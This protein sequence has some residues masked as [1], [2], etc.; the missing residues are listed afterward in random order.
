MKPL[1]EDW[2]GNSLAALGR[3]YARLLTIGL[4]GSLALLAACQE[5]EPVAPRVI[6]EEVAITPTPFEVTR[7]VT[8]E[9][10]V[11][12][13]PTPLP[14]IPPTPAPKDLTICLP[15]EPE[16]LYPYDL[17][18]ENRAILEPVLHAL[19]EDDFTRRSFGYQARGLEK[20]PSLADGDAVLEYTAVREGEWVV[21]S[22]GERVRLQ[23]GV[24]VL[25]ASG[26]EVVFSSGTVNMTQMTVD[27][28]MKPRMWSDGQPVSAEDSVL[29]FALQQAGEVAEPESWVALTASYEAIAPRTVRWTG[30]PGAQ[31][32]QYFTTFARPVPAHL[33]ENE[34]HESISRLVTTVPVGDGPFVLDV[35]RSG[36]FIR[37]RPNP[38]YYVAGQPRLDTLTFRFATDPSQ[39]L[40]LLLAGECQI[41]PPALVNLDSI[42]ALLSSQNVGELTLHFETGTVFE[43]IDFGID[44]YGVYGDNRPDWFEDARVR[45]AVALCT[46]RQQMVDEMLFGESEV[47]HSYVPAVHPLHPDAIMEW[48]YDPERGNALLDEVGFLDG[49]D[50]GI[51]EFE[52]TL[53][54]FRGDPFR[55][56]LVADASTGLVRGMIEQFQADMLA[57]GIEVVA[58]FQTTDE[59]FGPESDLFLRRFELG[60]YAWKAGVEPMCQLYHSDEITGPERE[61]YCGWT[62]CSNP[63]GFSVPAFDEACERAQASLPGQA[64]YAQSHQE[65][66]QIF[67]QLLPSLPLFWRIKAAVT[68]PEVLNFDLDPTESSPFWNLY[69]LDLDV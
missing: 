63:T 66:Q 31:V 8:R 7:I 35:W 32:R 44:S 40:G 22:D 12:I 56:R 20:L 50:D 52:G 19:Y 64:V 55:V 1:I 62:Y 39:A 65:A 27:F 2:S 68:R 14:T 57:C 37:M 48:P 59:I 11:E 3:R 16:T 13:S 25:N 53:P 23:V 47:A 46:N 28:H 34:A 21:D 18:E 30:L 60:A 10:L 15:G 41:L 45:Q 54:W 9:I 33:Y 6:V 61:G 5:Q 42:P 69:E 26:D 24:R 38:H 51:R 43:H 17:T 67:A 29:G 58:D 36:R 4:W 49:D